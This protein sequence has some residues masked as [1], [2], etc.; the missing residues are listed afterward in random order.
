VSTVQKLLVVMQVDRASQEL[1]SLGSWEARQC[2]G[3]AE[4]AAIAAAAGQGNTG[5]AQSGGS[6]Q[7]GPECSSGEAEPAGAHCSQTWGRHPAQRPRQNPCQV[8]GLLPHVSII[9]SNIIAGVHLPWAVS[10]ALVNAGAIN[11]CCHWCGLEGG[12][13]QQHESVCL[14]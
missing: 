14:W 5:A 1:P 11:S 12:D 4:P 13:G 10:S 8:C 6:H 9:I 7:P 3:W 2:G